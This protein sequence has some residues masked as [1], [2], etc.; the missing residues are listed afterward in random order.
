MQT[1]FI[2]I[3]NMKK[4]L[5]LLGLLVG[6]VHL[7]QGQTDSLHNLQN[8]TP[9]VALKKGQFAYRF[10]NLLYTQKALYANDGV[11]FESSER[12]TYFTSQHHFSYG[13]SKHLQLDTEIWLKSVR[14]DLPQN[15]PL[16][17]Y[18]FTGSDSIRTALTYA[19]AGVRWSPQPDKKRW[20]LVS[21]I[22]IPLTPNLESIDIVQ[23][24]LAED[25]F[26]WVN[27]IYFDQVVADKL[28]TF[29][30]AGVWWSLPKTSSEQNSILRLPFRG[31]LSYFASPVISAN[32]QA[33]FTFHQ[34]WQQ[35]QR[36]GYWGDLG[37]GLRWQIV[38]GALEL[39][40][41]Y[42]KYVLGKNQGAGETFN[43][44]V[45]WIRF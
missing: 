42:Q 35:P 14:A 43:F 5:L 3:V 41:D 12:I 31:I 36:S 28:Y 34:Q 13:I 18:Q 4:T 1:P 21:K 29:L 23:P 22:L 15:S 7:S 30:Q 27:E 16:Q 38:P 45:R 32:L 44:G 20:S 9:A 17:V 11:R 2:T 19:G 39:Q 24:F 33:G 25:H 10:W 37:I 6:L 40:A 26:W 8:Y